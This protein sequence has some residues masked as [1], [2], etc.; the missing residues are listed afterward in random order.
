MGTDEQ[1]TKWVSEEWVSEASPIASRIPS[2]V[3]WGRGT[4]RGSG[5]QADVMKFTALEFL[6]VHQKGKS[7]VATHLNSS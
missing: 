1:K 4:K 5:S 2:G 7:P 3:G 6:R